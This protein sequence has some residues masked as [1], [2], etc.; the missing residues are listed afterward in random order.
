MLGFTYEFIYSYDN[1]YGYKR[2]GKW[3]GTIKELIEKV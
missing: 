2:N 1:T 3:T